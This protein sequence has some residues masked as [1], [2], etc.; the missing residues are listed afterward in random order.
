LPLIWLSA[1]CAATMVL[2]L[3]LSERTLPLL[4]G[5]RAFTARLYK[6]AFMLLIAGVVAGL[7]PAGARGLALAKRGEH[8]VRLK[9]AP[10]GA[11][12]LARVLSNRAEALAGQEE[13]FA[14]WAQFVTRH[15]IPSQMERAGPVLAALVGIGGAVLAVHIW[16]TE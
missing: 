2:L 4:G 3:V 14:A 16:R 10:A 5:D 6:A 13:L 7:A 15:D 8:N 9:L 1:I 12:G 11:R